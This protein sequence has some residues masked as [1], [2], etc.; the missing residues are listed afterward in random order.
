MRGLEISWHE[1]PLLKMSSPRFTSFVT[2]NVTVSL[3]AASH[4]T[5]WDW[6]LVATTGQVTLY[7]TFDIARHIFLGYLFGLPNRELHCRVRGRDFLLAVE[8]FVGE[9]AS[10]SSDRKR[11]YSAARH[12]STSLR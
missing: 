10:R 3:F 9:V 4:R 2:D 6:G 8:A 11:S 1:R 5:D 12:T 7:H